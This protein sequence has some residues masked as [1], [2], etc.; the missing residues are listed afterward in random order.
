MSEQRLNMMPTRELARLVISLEGNEDFQALMKHMQ[1]R[2]DGLAMWA[3]LV[4]D[5]VKMRWA[6]G[7]VSEMIDW[8]RLWTGRR[9]VRQFFETQD[10]A[11]DG[12]QNDF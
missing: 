3:C 7:R 11:S 2:A 9:E 8:L 10:A 6:Q 4:E 5:E 1:E 12:V